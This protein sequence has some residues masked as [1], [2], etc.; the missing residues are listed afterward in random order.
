[1]KLLIVILKEIAETLIRNWRLLFVKSKFTEVVSTI[2]NKGVAIKPNFL[3][4][5]TCEKY[6]DII[7]KAIADE[8]VNT[9]VDDAGADHR[10]YFIN[11][12]SDE[13]NEFYTD[14]YIRQ[15]LAEYTGIKDPKGMLLAGRI[16]AV[17]GNVGSGGGWHRDSPVHHQTKAICYLSDVTDDN[18]PFQYIP[19]SNSK[20]SVIGAYLKGIFSPGQYRFSETEL[21]DYC[22]ERGQ[23]V[24]DM[25]AE[26]G[27]LLFADT[28]GIHRGKPIKNGRRYVLFC[29]FWDKKIPEHFENHKQNLS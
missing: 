8:K 25:T 11:E 28:K 1:M 15:V 13:L 21:N 23:E 5:E 19:S 7:D 6:I 20:A 18:G 12:L 26:A 24:V 29:Y 16:D 17:E 9:W 14:P 4:E 2:R 10:V 3:S 22:S 27:T